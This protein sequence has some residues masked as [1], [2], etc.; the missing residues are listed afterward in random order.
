MESNDRWQRWRSKVRFNLQQRLQL[1][2]VPSEQYLNIYSKCILQHL[3]R[4]YRSTRP[5]NSNFHFHLIH[6]SPSLLELLQRSSLTSSN[7]LSSSFTSVSVTSETIAPTRAPAPY[8]R[9]RKKSLRP[10]ETWDWSRHQHRRC[11]SN[12]YD[13]YMAPIPQ[14]EV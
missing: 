14:A 1:H 3:E 11:Y 7:S 5:A 10:V 12:R 8:N 9:L 13:H 4:N 2:A 6:K